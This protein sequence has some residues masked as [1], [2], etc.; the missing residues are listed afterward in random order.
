MSSSASEEQV[1]AA[2]PALTLPSFT[3]S[4]PAPWF[5]RVESL[6]RLKG[7]TSDSRK[8]DYVIGALPSDTFD[9]IATWLATKATDTILYTELKPTIIRLCEP[10]PEEKCQRILDLMKTPL[11]DQ[12]PSDAL[13][14][15]RSLATVLKPDGTTSTLDLVSL[16]W[17]TRLPSELRPHLSNFASRSDE[18]LS[19]LADSVR[20]T[21]KLVQPLSTAS[22]C[23]VEA[24]D[25]SQEEDFVQ[26][27]QYRRPPPRSSFRPA[28]P[29]APRRTLCYFHKRF[30]RAAINCRP[31]CYFSKNA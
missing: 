26:A 20:G 10:S 3:T 30:G 17:V 2:A 9:R 7:I 1:A 13:R 18:E 14:E 31:P 16:M 15:L 28:V 23:Q 29:D 21:S 5:Q 11:G 12:R 19:R 4:N 27:A 22:A 8:A 6:F 24:Q 25:E